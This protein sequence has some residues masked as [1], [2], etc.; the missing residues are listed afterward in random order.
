MEVSI[1]SASRLTVRLTWLGAATV[2][3]SVSF[4]GW[5]W[6]SEVS[7]DCVRSGWGVRFIFALFL[8]SRSGELE[9]AISACADDSLLRFLTLDLTSSGS[10]PSGVSMG[11]SGDEI[12][13]SVNSVGLGD[14]YQPPWVLR[15]ASRLTALAS[16]SNLPKQENPQSVSEE[17]SRARG[18]DSRMP[19]GSGSG[20]VT[21]AW[22]RQR[23]ANNSVQ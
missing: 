9:R 12:S 15:L 22:S 2:T 8:L 19:G 11:L 1:S 14:G 3:V 5:G 17:E 16:P 10:A 4:C 21:D 13:L 20:R 6:S 23:S 18:Q 7:F